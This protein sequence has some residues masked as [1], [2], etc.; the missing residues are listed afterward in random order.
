[1]Q[2]PSAGTATSGVTETPSTAT[3]QGWSSRFAF[4]MASVGFAVGLGN[5]WKFPYVAGEN[6]GGAFVLVYLLCVF[7]IGAP[8][9][10]AEVL[11]GR[12][13]RLSPNESMA[14]VA[15]E[16]GA[17][18][19]W[20]WVG[21]MTMTTAFLMMLIYS[22]V[23]GWVLQYLF[24]SVSG[25]VTTLTTGQ[26]SGE[27]F[28]DMVADPGGLFF[29]CVVVLMLT[30]GIVASGIQNGIERAVTFLM[31]LLFVLL[32][33]MVGY[34]AVAGA[35]DRGLAFLFSPDFSKLSPQAVLIAIGQAFFSVSVA[36][37]GMMTF[38]AYLPKSTSIAKSVSI[39]VCADT[40]V[41]LLAGLAIFPLVFANGLDPQAGPGLIFE[42]LPVAFAQMPG[43]YFFSTL[44]F[45]LLSVAA[46][47][48]NVGL[49]EPLVSWAEE[50]KGI[51]RRRAGLM[52]VG[53]SLV[54]CSFTALSFNHLKDFEPL[55]WLPLFA[56]MNINELLTF[57]IDQVLLP[58]G[59]LLIALFA[60][61]VM[62]RETTRDELAM[63]NPRLFALWYFLIR[64][65]VPVA[66]FL[67]LVLGIS[68]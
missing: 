44:F 23:A 63:A 4:I 57:L 11:I 10:M 2:I 41:A 58:V 3:H 65:I 36:M 12:R 34:A 43:G 66:V 60:G 67:V 29:W 7:A 6:G 55:G 25:T 17:S 45:L 20:H 13:G 18:K 9:L 35:F 61:W 30:G 47:T 68:E 8:I 19:H 33:A 46:I 50:H 26:A 15:H 21:A 27:L 1:M 62:H 53:I 32:L 31:P 5:I 28:A 37:A 22:V 64:Y 16:A 40:L 56:G 14:H 59:G 52:I 39:V 42:T 48:S 54:L 49:L 24:F 51:D 38:G